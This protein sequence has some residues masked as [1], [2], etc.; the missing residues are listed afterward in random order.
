MHL[1]FAS[2]WVLGI[3]KQ[4]YLKT[5]IISNIIFMLGL[6]CG[7]AL[8]LITDGL[9]TSGYVFGTIAEIFLGI[10]GIWVLKRL[11]LTRT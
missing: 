7:R 3:F 11:N 4:S 9:P 8:S 5:A 10:Y 6:G 1:G 2:L